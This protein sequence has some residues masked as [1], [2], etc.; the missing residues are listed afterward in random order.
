MLVGISLKVPR[1]STG[2]SGLGSNESICVTPPAIQRKMTDLAFPFPSAGPGF[3]SAAC[4]EPPANYAA[5]TPEAAMLTEPTRNIS[6]R[7]QRL[8]RP[9]GRLL[10]GIGRI[11]ISA[12]LTRGQACPTHY[13][14]LMGRVQEKERSPTPSK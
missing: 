9:R 2:A 7:F 14:R 5:R 3:P 8:S 6:R 12:G 13:Q 10:S 1:T 4:A 11:L